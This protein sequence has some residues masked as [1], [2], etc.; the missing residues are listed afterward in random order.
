MAVFE[1]VEDFGGEFVGGE[2]V[3]ALLAFAAAFC[4]SATR[5]AFEALRFGGVA[6]WACDACDA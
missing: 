4:C 5:P 6:L 2:A 1:T 3:T